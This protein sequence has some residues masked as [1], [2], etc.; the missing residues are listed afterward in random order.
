M[1]GSANLAG[2]RL[3]GRFRTGSAD[4]DA[5]DIGTDVTGGINVVV[6]AVVVLCDRCHCLGAKC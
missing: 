6:G 3:A 1:L 2:T 5:A 4:A